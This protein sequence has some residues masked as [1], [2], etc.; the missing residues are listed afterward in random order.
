MATP[1]QT[2][3]QT[4][5]HL[6]KRFPNIELSYEGLVHNKVFNADYVLAIPAGKKAFVWFTTFQQQHVCVLMEIGPGKK[7]D[8]MDFIHASFADSLANG[9]IFYG[10]VFQHHHGGRAFTVETL[11]YYRGK[12]CHYNT[13]DERLRTLAFILS[14]EIKQVTYTSK[15]IVFGI[16]VMRG[17]W[18]A[19]VTAS[20]K[21]PYKVQY[22]QFRSVRKKGGND[23]FNMQYDQSAPVPAIAAAVPV[24]K[25][26]TVFLAKPDLQNDIYH[27]YND[28]GDFHGTAC[29]PDYK[30]SV[31]MNSLFRNIKENDRLDAL[32]ESD[33]EADFEDNREEKHVFLDRQ[34]RMVCEYNFKFKKWTPI[35]LATQL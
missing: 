9:T 25:K 32:E 12:S 11:H 26:P 13:F 23:C 27:L 35:A 30:T 21:L 6:L 1:K 34:Y 7:I 20:A 31:F 15:S 19:L 2:E 18:T 3:T 16:P 33:D 10:T 4:Q 24:S 5:T 14:N 28:A 8:K 22:I 29:I 17:T